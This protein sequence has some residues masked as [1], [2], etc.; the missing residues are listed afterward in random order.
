MLFDEGFDVEDIFARH[1][2]LFV[3]LRGGGLLA[4]KV[5][6]KPEGLPFIYGLNGCAVR[7]VWQEVEV[8]EAIL[9]RCFS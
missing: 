8:W 3:K 1:G 9:P 6:G 2:I 7:E 5:K 4:R